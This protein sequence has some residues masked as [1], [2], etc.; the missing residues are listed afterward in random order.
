MW[1]EKLARAGYAAKGVVYATIGILAIQV[2][3]SAGGKTTGSSGALQSIASQP[4]GQILLI[5][6]AIG[7][8]GYSLWRLIEAIFDPEHRRTDSKNIAKRIGYLFSGIIY[9]A[10]GVQA[11]MIV[12]QASSSSQGSGNSTSDWTAK[13]M[14][15]PFGRWLV[16]LAG[17]ITIGVGLYRLY[18]AYKV[19]FRRKL[20]LREL[21]IKTEKWV[22]RISRF[23]I[24]ARGVIFVIIGFFFLQAFRQYDPSEAKG[25]DGVLQTLAQQPYGKILLGIVALGLIAY[26]I[27]LFVQS[28][29]RQIP[30]SNVPDSLPR[31][32]A[33]HRYK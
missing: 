3:I 10:L 28:R 9:G 25:L 5:L 26:S 22:I 7:L 2:A 29:Y 17:A 16:A 13:L 15:Q 33:N 18:Y 14:A 11:V 21:D 30:V 4:F 19:K 24:A 8:F 20:N 12:T 1:V 27:Y 6:V 32:L 23:G 31:E